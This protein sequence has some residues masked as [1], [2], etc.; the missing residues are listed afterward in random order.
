[1][2]IEA[3][4]IQ[5]FLAS[6]VS[7][8]GG[9]GMVQLSWSVTDADSLRIESDQPGAPGDVTGNVVEVDVQADTT[10]TLVAENEGGRSEESLVVE[11][12]SMGAPARDLIQFGSTEAD[13]AYDVAVQSDGSIYVVGETSGD[14]EGK[15][16]G[17]T[18]AFLAKFSASGEHSWTRQIGTDASDSARS[19]AVADDGSIYI[20]GRTLGDF[21]TGSSVEC[22]LARYFDNNVRDW[23]K[24]YDGTG[25]CAVA[26]HG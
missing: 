10:F 21:E 6:A 18:D 2:A 15:N 8:P 1:V 4:V 20:A 5:S 22:F 23:L 3:P 17:S 16:S 12:N 19:V 9:G 24:Q 25:G 13:Y 14:M 7:V 11:V 26:A